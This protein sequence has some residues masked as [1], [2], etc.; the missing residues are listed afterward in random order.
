VHFTVRKSGTS[1]LR[2]VSPL[3]FTSELNFLP[4]KWNKVA[5]TLGVFGFYA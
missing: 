1:R 2:A 5:E 4:E 3:V